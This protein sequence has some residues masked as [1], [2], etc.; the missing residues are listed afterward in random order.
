[1][2]LKSKRRVIDLAV[3]YRPFILVIF[4]Y[5]LIMSVGSCVFWVPLALRGR[6]DFRHLYTAGYMVRSGHAHEL[7]DS[8]AEFKFQ[9]ELAGPLTM[10]LPFNHLAY[11]ALFFLPLS[12]AGFRLAYLL[13]FGINLVLVAACCKMLQPYLTSLKTIWTWLPPAILFCF[14]PIAAALIQGQDSIIMLTLVVA[15][16]VSHRKGNDFWA[17][18]LVGLTVFKFH[19]SIPFLVLFLAWKWWRA[20]LGF[21][22][23]SAGAIAVSVAITGF[24]GTAVYLR[25]LV[26]MSLE[27]KTAQQQDFYGIHPVG[28]PNLRGLIY[29]LTSQHLGHLWMQ[30]LTVVLSAVLLLVAARSRPSFSLAVLVTVLVSYHALLHD[31]SLLVLPI[32][33]LGAASILEWLPY[34]GWTAALAGLILVLPTLLIQMPGYPWLLT[35]PVL[36]LTV[37]HLVQLAKPLEC[38]ESL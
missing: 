11:E 15:A 22:A 31:I 2:T 33:L 23:S 12:F 24:G 18:I 13:F 7:Y 19:F 34:S 38:P 4:A 6:M 17:G 25:S 16:F 32:G 36:A 28:M 3:S 35:V 8:D 21:L 20:A 5:M 27:L 29:A 1:M 10:T 30:I 26:S 9:N 37:L 14:Y